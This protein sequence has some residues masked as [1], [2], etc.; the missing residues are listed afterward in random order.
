RCQGAE[1]RQRRARLSNACNASTLFPSPDC[2]RAC[3]RSVHVSW[4]SSLICLH[5]I[6]L[7]NLVKPRRSKP[8]KAMEVR[9]LSGFRFRVVQAV[10]TRK[11]LTLQ[12]GGLSAVEE[13]RSLYAS[14]S[15]NHRAHRARHFFCSGPIFLLVEEMVQYPECMQM[16]HAPG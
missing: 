16:P 10:G 4:F 11:M 15:P 12:A 6:P 8:E 7:G 5:C 1:K 2:G 14:A 9:R 13:G 3:V